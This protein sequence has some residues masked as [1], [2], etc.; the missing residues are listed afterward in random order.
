MCNPAAL[1][2]YLSI[3]FLNILTL[4][5]CTHSADN[6]FLTLKGHCIEF[7]FY[8]DGIH[9]GLTPPGAG[10]NNSGP[11]GITKA[12]IAPSLF[13]PLSHHYRRVYSHHTNILY[14]AP[15]K[16]RSS[17]CENENFLTSNLLCF[18]TTEKVVPSTYFQTRLRS[19]SQYVTASMGL[20]HNRKRKK[21]HINLP[22]A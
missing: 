21:Q 11:A 17:S 9:S 18:F 20:C 8:A 12:E 13:T 22:T 3:I 5:A 15:L 4:L 6:L 19:I 16:A 14:S 1:T 10:V 2:R 7:K